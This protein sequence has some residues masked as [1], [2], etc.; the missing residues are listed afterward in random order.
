MLQADVFLVLSV[1][2][3]SSLHI[4][5]LP[6][7]AF[8]WQAEKVT[9]LNLLEYFAFGKMH[10]NNIKFIFQFCFWPFIGS[11]FSLECTIYNLTSVNKNVYC[12][13]DWNCNAEQRLFA[14]RF[15]ICMSC[16][17]IHFLPSLPF[18]L[19]VQNCLQ[20]E[21]ESCLGSP[22]LYQLIEVSYFTQLVKAGDVVAL[23]HLAVL[24][25]KY[26]H[27]MGGHCCTSNKVAAEVVTELNRHL[28]KRD[29]RHCRISAIKAHTRQHYSGFVW[30]SLNKQS[31]HID[32]SSFL[33]YCG[34]CIKG[35]IICVI[36]LHTT[37]VK[38]SMLRI[39]SST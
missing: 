4:H 26:I 35:A 20:T 33:Q 7:G 32:W 13:V 24:C 22:V 21:A 23:C 15:P 37:F 28:C 12:I 16:H 1:P 19:S 36:I 17:L 2:I 3:F 25:K 38:T 10:F 6:Q 27:G 29:S 11:C 31:W 9:R 5:T 34:I 18:S 14:L 30:F 8:W 39:R